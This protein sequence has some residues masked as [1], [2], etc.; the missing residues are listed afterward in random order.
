MSNGGKHA[1][2]KRTLLESRFAYHLR[3]LREDATNPDVTALERLTLVRERAAR[4]RGIR[5][6]L[7]TCEQMEGPRAR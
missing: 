1:S 3:F 7:A 5:Q 6:A 2:A 4:I